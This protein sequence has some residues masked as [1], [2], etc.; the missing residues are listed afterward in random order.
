MGDAKQVSGA[1]IALLG[2]RI[3]DQFCVKPSTSYLVHFTFAPVLRGEVRR[4]SFGYISDAAHYQRG[5]VL[6][7]P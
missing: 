6:Y 1:Q 4:E 7:S 5:R 2:D 3:F